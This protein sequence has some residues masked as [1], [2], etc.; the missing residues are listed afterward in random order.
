[1]ANSQGTGMSKDAA[2]MRSK[3]F[4]PLAAIV[5]VKL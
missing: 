3:M 1:M 4:N 2:K 5:I